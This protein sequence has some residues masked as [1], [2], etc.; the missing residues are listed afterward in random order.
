MKRFLLLAGYLCFSSAFA[1]AQNSTTIRGS[2]K[3]ATGDSVEYYHVVVS[4]LNRSDTVVLAGE[5]FFEDRF[6]M[7]VPAHNPLF[8]SV[9]LLGYR[10][11][12]IRLDSTASESIAQGLE[13]VLKP[14]AF[15]IQTVTITAKRPAV[16][17]EHGKILVDVQNSTLRDAGNVMD[18]F[19]RTPG[20]IATGREDFS[21]IGRGKP[22][23][24]VN[25]REIKNWEEL[26]AIRSIDIR[27][28]EVDRNPSP[29]YTAKAVVRIKT[30]KRLKDELSVQLSNALNMTRKISDNP[31]VRLS[32]RKKSVTS[33]LSY[34][35]N[36]INSKIFESS[37]KNIIDS[38]GV[39]SNTKRYDFLSHVNGHRLLTGV[40]V[41][42]SPKSSLG[43]QYFYSGTRSEHTSRGT[44]KIIG[45]NEETFKDFSENLFPDR[46]LHSGTIN[47][48]YERKPDSRLMFI[49]DYSTA[50]NTEQSHIKETN[51]TSHSILNTEIRNKSKYRIYTGHLKYSFLLPSRIKSD[52]GAQFSFVDNNFHSSTRTTYLSDL[53]E[54]TRIG[55]LTAAG[56]LNLNRAW[57][58]GE[59]EAGIRYEYARTRID[60]NSAEANEAE[61]VD[62]SF[63]DFLPNANIFIHASEKLKVRASYAR[64][65]S[66]PGFRELDPCISYEDSLSYVSGNPFVKP[67][68]E[69]EWVVGIDFKDMLSFSMRYVKTKD[70]R[71]QTYINDED[72][73][74]ILMMVP[75]NIPRSESFYCEAFFNYVARKW[76]FNC[77]AGLGVPRV[78]VPFLNGRKLVNHASWECAA[79]VNLT[80]SKHFELYT[81]FS[82]S[83][84]SY[85]LTTYQFAYNNLTVGMMGYFCQRKL[86]V[87]IEG[88]DLLDGSN[89]N[90]WEDRYLNVVTRNRGNFDMRGVKVAVSYLFNGTVKALKSRR[91]NTEILQRAD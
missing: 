52:A 87:N 83:S 20:M 74:N 84:P 71:L 62:R 88:T 55:D 75:I 33:V 18:M 65:V 38:T 49:A 59:L 45:R 68:Y 42:I 36:H 39:F 23:V 53:S 16:K 86:T 61:E 78:N 27:S 19:R 73:S 91:G 76:S 54:R 29:A 72:N 40:D 66:R 90:N 11:S 3:L 34:N 58:F 7:K 13:F 4:T 2:V 35:Y 47:Y 6:E 22:L 82:Y 56:Y 44:G 21:V 50:A 81:N 9:S 12:S 26:E 24:I 89:W 51:L 17:L 57:K 31:S 48:V 69:N 70:A 10:S 60:Q 80:L 25:D 41:T 79:N 67:S 37:E 8:V 15:H 63:S 1:P 64:R 85:S 46:S 14:D 5:M 30:T 43:F 32:F 77:M 28:I